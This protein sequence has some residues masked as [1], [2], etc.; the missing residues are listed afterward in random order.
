MAPKAAAPK[1]AA[2]K[3]S[4]GS[5]LKAGTTRRRVVEDKAIH[6]PA[7]NV[8]GAGIKEGPDPEAGEEFVT[9]SE[10]V[11]EDRPLPGTDLKTRVL[12]ATAGSRVLKSSLPKGA[13]TAKAK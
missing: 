3:K 8:P 4:G 1:K 5:A 6:G 13:K 10:D 11:Y 12:I 2:A 9:V 7:A